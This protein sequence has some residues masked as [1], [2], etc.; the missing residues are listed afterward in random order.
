MVG[1]RP[2][3]Q[4]C[5]CVHSVRGAGWRLP[6]RAGPLGAQSGPSVGPGSSHKQRLGAR[7]ELSV[8]LG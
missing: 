8:G 4:V 6:D 3:L 1:G 5:L 7:L 2:E